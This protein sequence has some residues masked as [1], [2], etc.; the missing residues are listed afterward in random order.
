MALLRLSWMALLRLSW[1]ALLR[2]SWMAL[3]RL[4][5]RPALAGRDSAPAEAGAHDCST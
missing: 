1:M 5:S 4:S 3:L 2:L